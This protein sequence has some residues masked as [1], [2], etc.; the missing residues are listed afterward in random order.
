[1]LSYAA[2]VVR[3]IIY[4]ADSSWLCLAL[5]S[6]AANCPDSEAVRYSPSRPSVSC[7]SGSWQLRMR[8]GAV[9]HQPQVGRGCA[10]LLYAI[11]SS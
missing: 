10:Y 2:D 6:A 9:G 4:R 5:R 1:M 3:D 7:M 8:A 11:P